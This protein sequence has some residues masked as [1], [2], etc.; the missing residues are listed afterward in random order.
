VDSSALLALLDS[1]DAHHAAAGEW[2]GGPGRR[3]LLLSHSYVVVETTALVAR[4]LGPKASK[5]L[6]DAW[7][8]EL[9]VMY[10]DEELHRQAMV[11]Y[12]K[13]LSRRRSFVDRVSFEWMRHRQVDTAFAFDADFR[14]EGFAVVP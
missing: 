10:V 3:A 5:V 4:R 2:V 6:I 8:P 11:A 7:L 13:E 12:R 1:D 9:S 14:K